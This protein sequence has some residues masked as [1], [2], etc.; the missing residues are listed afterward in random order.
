MQMNRVLWLGMG[1]ILTA[2]LVSGCG[3]L[4]SPGQK[5][6]EGRVARTTTLEPPTS[7]VPAQ[8]SFEL[9]PADAKVRV[10]AYYPMDEAR[11]PLM[12]LLKSLAKQYQGKVYVKCTDIRTP[13]GTAAR[14]RAGGGG[15]GL[16]INS[17]NSVLIEAKP[18]PYRVE[19][20]Q[21]MGR[22]WTAEDLKAAVAQE[23]ARAYGK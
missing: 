11:Q 14:T 5:P 3:R 23:V 8:P 12:D 15:P 2:F 20:N 17:Q 22:Y 9:G 10:V 6:F 7:P 1:V 18:N 21:D 4:R 19:F 16:L 13:E